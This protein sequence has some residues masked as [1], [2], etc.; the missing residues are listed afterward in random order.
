MFN[1]IYIYIYIYILDRG[2]NDWIET[3]IY[4][5]INVIQSNN[6]VILFKKISYEVFPVKKR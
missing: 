2:V 6:V 5:L 1:E 3:I 4:E